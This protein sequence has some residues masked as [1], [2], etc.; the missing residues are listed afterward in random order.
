MLFQSK[1]AVG[2]LFLSHFVKS[3]S[4]DLQFRE[5]NSVQPVESRL[6]VS[7]LIW[8]NFLIEKRIF[9]IF[10]SFFAPKMFFFFG[11]KLKSCERKTQ[12]AW[13]L[14]SFVQSQLTQTKLCR[15]YRTSLEGRERLGLAN[16]NTNDLL[17]SFAYRHRAGKFR[18]KKILSRFAVWCVI[19]LTLI[20][21][22]FC[23]SMVSRW[24][25][26]KKKRV[27]TTRRKRK[28]NIFSTNRSEHHGCKKIINSDCITV[29][30][31]KRSV[32][33]DTKR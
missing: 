13:D 1:S 19:A 31:W 26:K 17:V 5:S 27:K 14:T 12:A 9:D 25:R 30:D 18:R 22:S 15:K 29:K 21:E 24:L 2:F 32:R 8:S 6:G 28:K 11:E 7:D 23:M 16:T 20:V 4:A 3:N 10:E 33:N